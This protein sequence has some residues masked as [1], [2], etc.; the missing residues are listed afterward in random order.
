MGEKNT[1]SETANRRVISAKTKWDVVA[2]I[3][4]PRS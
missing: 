4:N 2:H 3:C 1:V